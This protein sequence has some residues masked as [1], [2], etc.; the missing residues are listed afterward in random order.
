[1]GK[2]VD[3]TKYGAKFIPLVPNGKVPAAKIKNVTYSP[4]QLR[5]YLKRGCNL[6]LLA[7]PHFIFIDVDTKEAHGHD[8]LRNFV[9]W[10]AQNHIDPN[11]VNNTLSQKTPS[12]GIHFIFL[13][14][15]DMPFKQD[16]NFLEGVDIKASVNNYI[17]IAPS[18][19]NGGA[20]KFINPDAEVLP[21]PSK[22]YEALHAQAVREGKKSYLTVDMEDFDMPVT[23]MSDNKRYVVQGRKQYLDL[24]YVLQHG[25]GDPAH[26]SA[27]LHEFVS[28]I[29][30]LTTPDE[31]LKYAQMANG[32]TEQPLPDEELRQSIYTAYAYLKIDQKRLAHI[33]GVDFVKLSQGAYVSLPVYEAIHSD[34][35]DD[36]PAEVVY[37]KDSNGK[38]LM[39]NS[40]MLYQY[41]A[42]AD[43]VVLDKLDLPVGEID[44]LNT[45]DTSMDGAARYIQISK[46]YKSLD[47]FYMISHG[48]GPEGQR[49]DNIFAFGRRMRKLTTLS[50]ALFFAEQAN[51][52]GENPYSVDK[53]TSTIKSAYAYLMVPEDRTRQVNGYDM[54][55]LDNHKFVSLE[56]FRLYQSYNSNNYPAPLLYVQNRNDLLLLVDAN[57]LKDYNHEEDMA[58]LRTLM[59]KQ[60]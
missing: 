22:L 57:E 7:Q 38:M 32:N 21:L 55:E 56:A 15:D 3:L 34:M 49:N 59:D 46:K 1:M 12:G 5:D 18:R 39:P 10:L 20:Y 8:G 52:N 26:Q 28:T 25:F 45:M 53:L 4:E 27:N 50:T 31:A 51:E 14:P 60:G 54:V 43:Q 47:P 17:V 42:A 13:Q 19:V 35:F 16:I 37:F 9:Q 30:R 33:R 48:F 44:S 11:V 41:S 40:H 58:Y 29:K 36:Y 6:G 23:K 24:F 2:K